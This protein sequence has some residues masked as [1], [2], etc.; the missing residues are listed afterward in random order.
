M[1]QYYAEP[2]TGKYVKRYGFLSCARNFSNN[3]KQLATGLDALKMFSKKLVNKVAE[4]TG[5]FIGNKI[6][7]AVAKSKNDKIVKQKTAIGENSR[8]VEE[9][10]I[11]PDK[12]EKISNEL[13]QL[14]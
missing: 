7:D 9:I 8:N 14:P 11:P 10:I 1:R 12:R 2:R 13:R 4:T 6:E 5:E 3:G